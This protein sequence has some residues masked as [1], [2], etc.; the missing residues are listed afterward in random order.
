MKKTLP[1][2]Y[3]GV[4][5]TSVFELYSPKKLRYGIFFIRFLEKVLNQG[6][7]DFERQNNFKEQS[8]FKFKNN[9][10]REKK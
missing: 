3:G 8:I 10:R 7:V 5:L 9:I 6:S 1:I 4:V 2:R